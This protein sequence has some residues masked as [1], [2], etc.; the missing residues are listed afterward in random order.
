MEN[1]EALGRQ[2]L[3]KHNP[4]YSRNEHLTLFLIKFTLTASLVVNCSLGDSLET[5]FKTGRRD[6]ASSCAPLTDAVATISSL[7]RSLYQ[8]S[9]FANTVIHL[10]GPVGSLT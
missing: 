5:P 3:S 4:T 10:T 1:L 8:D 9:T 7:S 6:G 2:V